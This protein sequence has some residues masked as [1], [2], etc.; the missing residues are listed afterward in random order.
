VGVWVYIYAQEAAAGVDAQRVRASEARHCSAFHTAKKGSDD[1]RCVCTVLSHMLSPLQHPH[2]LV[3][4]AMSGGGS[5]GAMGAAGLDAAN[6]MFT[7]FNDVVARR[8]SEV[9][10]ARAKLERNEVVDLPLC[11]MERVGA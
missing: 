2:R 9:E 4:V 5:E 10:F 1:G 8:E 6:E 11:R 3:S 7:S